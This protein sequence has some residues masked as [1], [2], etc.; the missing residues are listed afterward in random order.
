MIGRVLLAAL[1]AGIAAGLIF[2]GIQHVRLTPF[3]LAAE[4]YETAE[5]GHSHEEA[6]PAASAA[7][8]TEAGHDHAAHDHAGHDH[9]DAWTPADGLE[10]TLAT[11]GSSMMAGA[12]FAVLLAGISL[13]AGIP[14]TARNG[15]IWGLCGFIAVTLAPS[16]GLPPE[17]PG[18]PA[19][20]LQ[21][22]QL[23][24]VGTIIATGLGLYLLATRRA[25]GWMAAAVLLIALPHVIGA[26]Q[27][28]VHETGVPAGLAASF[29]ANAIAAGAVFWCIIG[30]FVGLAMD[31]YGKGL[32]QS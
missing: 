23:W 7:T 15:L 9:A 20:D 11:T 21:G 8:E 30:L 10:R 26:P 17:L 28:S 13:L 4:V 5:A 24:W 12:G 1:L 22:R 27:P 31:R 19:A 2:A 3:I 16:A 29:A 14:L 18:M 6:V 32:A 25:L